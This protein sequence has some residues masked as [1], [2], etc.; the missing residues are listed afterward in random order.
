MEPSG[1]NRLA[2]TGR[3]RAAASA[4]RTGDRR[5]AQR[6]FRPQRG[7]HHQPRNNTSTGP[8]PPDTHDRVRR[9][10]VDATGVITLRHNGRLHH[11]GIGRTHARTHVLLLVQDL[12]MKRHGFDAVSF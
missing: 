6:S 1:R 4:P 9:D 5:T 12:D 8:S 2:A 10:R 7:V 3:R 11:I